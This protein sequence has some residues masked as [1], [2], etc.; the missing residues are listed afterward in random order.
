MS[1]ELDTPDNV[2]LQIWLDWKIVSSATE[3]G[4]NFE[5]ELFICDCIYT[6]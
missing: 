1:S 3:A 6:L 4:F 2:Y 5:V